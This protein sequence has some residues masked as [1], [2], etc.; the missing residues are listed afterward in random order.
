MANEQNVAV[1]RYTKEFKDLMSVV[2]ESRAYFSD[3]FGGGVEALDGISDNET[4][5]SVKTSDIPVVVGTYDK[6]AT[7]A[8]GTGTGSGSRFGNRT[9]VIYTNTDVPYTW[10]WAFHEGIDRNTVNNDFES[11]VADRLELQAQAQTNLFNTHQGKFISDSAAKK[12]EAASITEDEV[13]KAFNE[14]AKYFVN[15]GAVGTKVAKVTPDVWNVIVDSK[16]MTTSK[17]SDV[18][19]GANTVNTFKGFQLEVVPDALFQ[20]NEC[21]LAYISGVGKAF[22]GI[23]TARTIESEDFDGVA[24]QGA[25]KAGEYILPANKKAVAKVT[26]NAA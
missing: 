13:V 9:E 8:F 6:T 24:L 15:I 10:N 2:F 16:L 1:R 23:Q 19:I 20:K 25:G 4:A 21:V 5:F 14:L 11:A 26:V 12:I 22:T 17:N 18:N 3:F 7:K